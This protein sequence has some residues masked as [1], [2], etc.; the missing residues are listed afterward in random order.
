MFDL[1]PANSSLLVFVSPADNSHAFD[2]V[3]TEALKRGIRRDDI[4]LLTP[5]GAADKFVSEAGV[6]VAPPRIAINGCTI[7]FL[8]GEP[9][10]RVFASSPDRIVSAELAASEADVVIAAGALPFTIITDGKAWHSCGPVARPANDGTP[11]VWCS[12]IG[13]GREGGSIVF[14]HIA[15]D[16]DHTSAARYM[17]EEQRHE[18]AEEILSGR[19]RSVARLPRDEAKASGATLSPEPVYFAKGARNFRWPSFPRSGRLGGAKFNDPKLTATGERRARVELTG[20]RTLW[21]N[22]GTLCNLA[23]ANCYIESTPRNDRLAYI[24]ADEAREYLDEIARD[25]LPTREIGF[26]GG[27]PFL[28]P[29]VIKMLGDALGRGFDVLMLT[30]AMKPMRRFDAELLALRERFGDRLTMRVSID[31]YTQR[32]H[33]LERGERSWQPTIDGLKWL[34][35]NGF[36]LHVAGRLYSGESEAAVRDGFAKLFEDIGVSVDAGDPVSL[37]LFPEMDASLDV[38]EIT[39]SCWGILHKSPADIMCASSRMVVKRK[40]A[41]RPSV[42]ACTLIA[43]DERFE[44]GRTLKEASGPVSLNHPHCAKFCVLGGAACSR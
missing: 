3:A 34:S 17:S 30:N 22:T 38:P 23:C 16:Y 40:G 32:L 4:L 20:L 27:E 41:Q 25:G 1:A 14:E 15:L 44:T 36:R 10:E 43:Y 24:T 18:E 37:V 13:P 11:R 39:E 29:H 6:R 33:E 8:A 26:T 31:H 19:W 28:N 7:R 12:L 9:A 42:Q 2:A 35:R 21:I 5:S